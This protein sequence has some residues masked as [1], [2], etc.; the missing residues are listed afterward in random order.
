MKKILLC[1]CV[2]VII[3]IS[4]IIPGTVSADI[5]QWEDDNGTVHFTDTPLNIPK[6][7]RSRQKKVQRTPSD[8]NKPGLTIIETS[9][10]N[11]SPSF[12]PES[13]AAEPIHPSRRETPQMQKEQLEARIGAKERFIES[14]DLKRSHALNPLGNRFVSPEDQELYKKYSSELPQDRQQLQKL[15]SNQ[16]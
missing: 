7:Y 6:K 9:S 10:Q 2:I 13:Y 14:I 1:V 15:Q 3:A 4:L 5:Y 12:D 16:P 8:N 11:S